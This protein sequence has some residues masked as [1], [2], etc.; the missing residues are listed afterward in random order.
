MSTTPAPAAP[1][2]PATDSPLP[3][4]PNPTLTDDAPIP[5]AESAIR[6]A[7]AE[8]GRSPLQGGPDRADLDALIAETAQPETAPLT[9]TLTADPGAI[10][11]A[12]VLMTALA[13]I[14]AAAV[15]VYRRVTSPEAR[16]RRDAMNTERIRA[17]RRALDAERKVAAHLAKSDQFVD[18]RAF[19]AEVADHSPEA[20]HAK[21]R[22]EAECLAAARL[23]KSDPLV[24]E[25]EDGDR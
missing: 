3:P 5:T 21:Q 23:M 15:L 6:D 12:L 4:A 20:S 2:A 25:R 7:F 16:E 10:A 14:A 24:D 8:A 17:K 9:V 19:L 18:E 13:G 11:G 1:A 22:L